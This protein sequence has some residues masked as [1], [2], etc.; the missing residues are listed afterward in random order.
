MAVVSTAIVHLFVWSLT[1]A[2]LDGGV[3]CGMYSRLLAAYW[4]IVGSFRLFRVVRGRSFDRVLIAT[5][6]L[7]VA[8]CALMLFRIIR[9]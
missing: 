9:V 4:L 7:P 8:I 2:L 5:A 6:W 3:V 1:A